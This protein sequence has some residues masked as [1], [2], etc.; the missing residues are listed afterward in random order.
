MVIDRITKDWETNSLN[1]D[2]NYTG[3]PDEEVWVVPD[4]SELAGKVQSLVKR[5]NPVLDDAGELI[6]VEWDGTEPV[7]PEPVPEA[8]VEA[9]LAELE[10][11]KAD[12]AD[13]DELNEALD[14]L[15]S[16]VTE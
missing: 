7:K 6:D 10:T 2:T 9:R 5:W 4:G 13:V 1:P 15:L 12:Q 11:N 3:R 16:G 14:L 8:S